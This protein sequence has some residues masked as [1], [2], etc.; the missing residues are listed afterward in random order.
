MLAIPLITSLSSFFTQ[1]FFQYQSYSQSFSSTTHTTLSYFS[2]HKNTTMQPIT[3][4]AAILAT[5]ATPI[6]GAP[7]PDV[8]SIS[9][10][11][12]V[13]GLPSCAVCQ[14]SFLHIEMLI[15]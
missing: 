1:D 8:A 6:A 4:F 10:T 7:I 11:A 2:L 13:K 14:T 12:V 3:F 15:Y 5:L 9:I